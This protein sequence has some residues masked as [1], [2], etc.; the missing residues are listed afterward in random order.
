MTARL[1]PAL[2]PDAPDLSIEQPL[3][4]NR[5]TRVAG[6]DEAGRG[7]WAGPVT[8]AV[9]VLH[10]S[11]FPPAELTEVRDSKQLSSQQRTKLELLIK[12]CVQ[13]WGVGFASSREIDHLGIL[14]ATRLAM[15]R[16]LYALHLEPMHLLIDALFLPEI[17]IPQTSLIKG[18]QRS[19]SIA[20]ASILAKTARDR[21]MV[22]YACQ[23]KAYAFEHNKGYGTREHMAALQLNGPCAEHRFYYAPIRKLIETD[24]G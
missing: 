11:Q 16:A 3:W 18:D 1:D 10:P 24:E 4:A 7:A 13:D 21:W 9:V 12:S 5:V 15:W 14:P 17:Q 2:V 20:S 8:A 22:E 6:L 23:A 19:L